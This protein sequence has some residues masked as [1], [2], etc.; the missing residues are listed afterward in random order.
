MDYKALKAATMLGFTEELWDSDSFISIYSKPFKDLSLEEKNAARYLGLVWP[1][2]SQLNISETFNLKNKSPC[3]YTKCFFRS[4]TDHDTG[5]LMS[6]KSLAD[7]LLGSWETSKYLKKHY[8]IRTIHLEA[9]HTS[10]IT[11]EMAT[12]LNSNIYLV[13]PHVTYK[14]MNVFSA[15][16]PVVYQKVRAVREPNF[17]LGCK[18]VRL[19]N[20]LVEWDIFLTNLP[21]VTSFLQKVKNEFEVSKN[22]LAKEPNLSTDYQLLIDQ[23]GNTFNIDLW[24]VF[25]ERGDHADCSKAFAMLLEAA[26]QYLGEGK[27]MPHHK[28]HS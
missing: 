7:E 9:P 25:E 23:D 16:T 3:G 14:N 24:N 12:A 10:T 21:N 11:Q 26:N 6:P 18:P 4:K 8:S 17:Q 1:V 27:T 15:E 2:W 22:L 5:Y 19:R 13:K 20:M 28:K